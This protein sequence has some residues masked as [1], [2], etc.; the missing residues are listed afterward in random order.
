M[1]EKRQD[2]LKP[3]PADP[4]SR[5]A[6]VNL[7]EVT[8]SEGTGGS[9]TEQSV[10]QIIYELSEQNASG[11]VSDLYSRAVQ[12]SNPA[13]RDVVLVMDPT[14][15]VGDQAVGFYVRYPGSTKAK[16][17]QNEIAFRKGKYFVVLMSQSHSEDLGG[18]KS[19]ADK[20]GSWIPGGRPSSSSR[21]PSSTAGG[22][23]GLVPEYPFAVTAGPKNTIS[24]ISFTITTPAGTLPLDSAKTSFN[25][26]VP[27]MG[28][29]VS[30]APGDKTGQLSVLSADN[31]RDFTP[32]DGKVKVAWKKTTGE[33]NSILEPGEAATITLDVAAAGF[34]PPA[35]NIRQG[36]A[37]LVGGPTG[38]T[39]FSCGNVPEIVTPG[40][41]YD[42]W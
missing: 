14:M 15:K 27:S 41:T 20:A 7:Y 42:C 22:G 1:T 29:K 37:I 26:Q 5:Y 10:S 17:A 35:K 18:L 21:A 30:P 32:G 11:A 31:F 9:D 23:A 38:G 25:V 19:L 33:Q 13:N 40:S 3:D 24:S 36:V 16:F 12:A 28:G 6:P 4:V 34:T 8:F 2:N 39:Q